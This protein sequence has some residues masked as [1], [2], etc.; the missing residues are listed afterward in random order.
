MAWVKFQF[1]LFAILMVLANLRPLFAATPADY[2][3]LS[4]EESM[5]ASASLISDDL[6]EAAFLTGAISQA[7]EEGTASNFLETSQWHAR[8]VA[9]TTAI[10]TAKNR[11]HIQLLQSRQIKHLGLMTGGVLVCFGMAGLVREWMRLRR[12]KAAAPSEAKAL[13]IRRKPGLTKS[14]YMKMKARQEKLEYMRDMK[15]F[16]HQVRQNE[17][18]MVPVRVESETR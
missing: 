14:R 5:N 4:G 11:Q 3:W 13:E 16:V 1:P 10:R 18:Q 8:A 7:L 12:V 17:S 2:P 6:A 15:D 9:K